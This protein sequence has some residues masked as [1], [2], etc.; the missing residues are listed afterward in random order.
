MT[1]PSL[2]EDAVLINIAAD[3]PGVFRNS[4][5]SNLTKVGDYL[6]FT[7]SDENGDRDLYRYATDPSVS[8]E[9]K[10]MVLRNSADPFTNPTGLSV[11]EITAGAEELY[12]E[13]NNFLWRIANPEAS[14]VNFQKIDNPTDETVTFDFGAGTE[15]VSFKDTLYFTQSRELWR[16]NTTSNK[17]ERV[18]N[19][20]SD[21]SSANE[22]L[23]PSE[24]TVVSTGNGDLLFFKGTDEAGDTELWISDGEPDFDYTN[25]DHTYRLKDI[26]SGATSS[27]ISNLIA[28]G[29]TLYFTAD[30]TD[31]DGNSQG[32]ELWR[33]NGTLEGTR[34]S[35][36]LLPAIT[37]PTTG[38]PITDPI[39]GLPINE[40]SEPN[41]LINIGERL[42]FSADASYTPSGETEQIGA[43]R[44]LWA[45]GIK[46]ET[47]D[48]LL[49]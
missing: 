13:A 40:G 16:V 41:N 14:T 9:N 36:D 10:L 28:I 30:G 35:V 23:D 22:D 17:I 8:A 21:N 24:L 42:F 38:L 1:S 5:P 2:G 3:A 48:D 4:N 20:P 25:Q 6:Y 34:M 46:D 31:N 47:A 27:R 33:S 32:I 45:V 49:T 37:D 18:T 11:V 39:T 15:R 26:Y 7:A 44:E 19:L 43:G 29:N 12:F